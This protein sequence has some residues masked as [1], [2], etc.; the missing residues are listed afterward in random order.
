VSHGIT[1][2]PELLRTLGC[3][4]LTV[5]TPVCSTWPACTVCGRRVGGIRATHGREHCSARCARGGKR[6]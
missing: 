6:D 4:T 2:T 3:Q 5:E 1:Y